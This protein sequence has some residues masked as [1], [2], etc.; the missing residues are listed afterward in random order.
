MLATCRIGEQKLSCLQFA[1]ST[2]NVMSEVMETFCVF[3]NKFSIDMNDIVLL[4]Y[5]YS[6][7]NKSKR[8]A[9]SLFM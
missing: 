5:F 8:H 1:S 9:S 3:L 4:F 6:R 2:H 7:R